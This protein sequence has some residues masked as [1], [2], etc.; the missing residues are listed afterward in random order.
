MGLFERFKKEKID[1][2]DDF[3]GFAYMSYGELMNKLAALNFEWRVD[4][5]QNQQEMIS[6]ISNIEQQLTSMRHVGVDISEDVPLTGTK[7]ERDKKWELQKQAFNAKAKIAASFKEKTNMSTIPLKQKKF[8]YA[9]END[10]RREEGIPNEF[11]ADT[12]LY[13]PGDGVQKKVK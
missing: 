8:L 7:E 12:P 13:T 10:W 9:S 2:K 11:D 3:G 5:E 6:E 1:A 4:F